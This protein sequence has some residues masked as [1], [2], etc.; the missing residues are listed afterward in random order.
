MTL[1]ANKIY[2]F[3]KNKANVIYTQLRGNILCYYYCLKEIHAMHSE[4]CLL[5][6]PS[7]SQAH[8]NPVEVMITKRTE[9]ELEKIKSTSLPPQTTMLS[10]KSK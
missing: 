8:L 3:T 6:R 9:T 7:K 2:I 1:K 5:L 10:N 4:R